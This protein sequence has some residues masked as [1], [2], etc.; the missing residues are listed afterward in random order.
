MKTLVLSLYESYPPVCGA[1]MVTYNIAK[2]LK[3][4]T[5]L[6][7]LTTRAGDLGDPE[8]FSLV[9]VKI[10]FDHGL[11]KVI[12]V[13]AKFPGILARIKKINPEVLILEGAAW[14]F[15][16]ALLLRAARLM[17]IRARIVYHSHNVEY[18]L[19]KQK[20][21]PLVSLV[22][23]WSE[24]WLLNN[25]H[26]VTAVSTTDARHFEDLYGARCVI[27]P[28]GVDTDKFAGIPE[29]LVGRVKEKY[30]LCGRTAL[31]MGLTDFGPN[32]EALDFLI[33]HVF[34]RVVHRCPDARLVVIGGDLKTAKPWLI[35]PGILPHEDVP[36]FVRACD[37]CLA[38]I[39]SG[40]GTRLKILEYMAAGKAVIS[41]AKGAE[42]IDVEPG[43]DIVIAESRDDFVRDI[44][45]LL[46]DPVLARGTGHEA[47]VAVR[48]KYSWRDIA[49]KLEDVSSGLV[50]GDGMASFSRRER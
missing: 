31:F 16:Y 29:S 3:G 4:K 33:D 2:Y 26:L 39:F 35:N 38:P 40:S 49:S 13:F 21:G 25:A 10:R 30:R 12:N 5:F 14:V 37:I 28:N 18:L 1:A 6:L 24:A 11:G 15:Y 20:N 32:R 36:P 23:K 22:T 9:N 41:T 50:C 34:P 43:R 7:Q 48:Q 44:C 17:K 47:M 19:R 42:G 27:I 8:S 45:L 46:N